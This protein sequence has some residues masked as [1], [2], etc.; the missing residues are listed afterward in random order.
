V[1][2]DPA[3]LEFLVAKAGPD[4]VLLGSDYPFP[5]GDLAPRDVVRRAVLRDGDRAAIIGGNAARLLRK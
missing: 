2:F 5:I 1:V 4:R 3:V